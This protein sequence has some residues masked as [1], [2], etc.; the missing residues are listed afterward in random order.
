MNNVSKQLKRIS[1]AAKIA[2]F[3]D[4]MSKISSLTLIVLTATSALKASIAVKDSLSE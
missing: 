3:F 1:V 4:L 2:S